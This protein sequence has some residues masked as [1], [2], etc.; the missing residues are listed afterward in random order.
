MMPRRTW[1]S[2]AILAGLLAALPSCS[3]IKVV[4][5]T[6]REALFASF[7][8]NM[9]GDTTPAP[10]TMQTLR[11]YDLEKLYGEDVDE[12]SARLL[13]QYKSEPAP[14]I[15]YALAEISYLVG[16]KSERRKRPTESL[17]AYYRA[18]GYAYHYLFAI[19]KPPTGSTEADWFTPQDSF[20]PRFRLAC[21]LYNQSLGKFIKAATESEQLDPRN[22]LRIPTPDGDTFQLSV[23]QIGFVWK[24]EDF[25]DLQLCSDYKVEGLANHYRTYGLGVPLI[26]TRYSEQLPSDSYLPRQLSF[27]VTG[28]LRFDGN[29]D[30]LSRCR[31]GRLELYDPLRIQAI[32]VR[33]VR[34]PLESDVTTPMAYNLANSELRGNWLEGFLRP[35]RIEEETGIY[36]L[37]PYNPSK[38]PVLFIH[39]L[40][41]SPLTWA[42]MFNDLGAEPDLRQRYQ[43]WF[44][45]YPTSAPY[46]VSAADL[47]RRLDKLRQKVDPKCDEANFKRM[48]LVSH[49]M[50]GLIAKLQTVDSGNAFWELT[51]EQPLDTLPV[52]DS[53]KDL[54][55]EV[56]YFQHN[57]AIA[58]VVFIGTPHRG[59]GLSTSPIGRLGSRLAGVPR[60][61]LRTG[62]EILTDDL[63]EDAQWRVL[64]IPNSVDMLRPGSPALDAL[65]RLPRPRETTYYSIVGVSGK[66]DMPLQ[67]IVGYQYGV[68]GD[69]VV[70]YESAHI[71]NVESELIVPANHF[72]EHQHPLSV[73]EVRRILREHLAGR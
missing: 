64:K 32:E 36:M 59:S 71:G 23:K 57:P 31:C 53:A 26:A 38:I 46:L 51:G 25:N 19:G 7:K 2:G 66:C 8:D 33:G 41:S 39:G 60:A 27:P 17:A 30:D 73:L 11:K 6:Q 5:A 28:F 56:L 67:R 69:G 68:V 44:Y 70:P 37:E 43:F 1:A 4:P 55:R 34:V 24:P 45:F 9:I 61:L 58:K 40:L 18:A 14:D 54:L 47:R 16:R 20:D 50:G 12:T 49:S 52:S 35:Q 15:L 22:V 63:A 3:T 48:V 10:R 65:L 13:Q 72:T 29:L 21:E 62:R 42:P